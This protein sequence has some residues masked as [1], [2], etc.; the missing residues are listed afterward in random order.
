MFVY[1]MITMGYIVSG[2]FFFKFWTRSRD[3][4]FIIFALAFWL[5]AVSQILLVILDIPREEQGWVYI[6]RFAAFVLIIAA[7]IQKNI[8][9]RIDR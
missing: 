6:L 1:G 5:L 4:L 9:R 3:P 7:I 2:L 8:S